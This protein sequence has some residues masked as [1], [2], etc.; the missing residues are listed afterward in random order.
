[1]EKYLYWILPPLVG[2]VIGYVTNAL[3]I[4]MLFRPLTEKR[5]FGLRVPFTP[6]ILPRER[7]TLALSLGDVVAND[8]L[9]TEVLRARFESE[10]LRE[11]VV[12]ALRSVLDRILDVS[13]SGA[14]HAAA[15]AQPVF[16][17]AVGNAYK[18]VSASDAFRDAL[19][20]AVRSAL[21]AVETLQITDILAPGGK[22]ILT[23]W[24]QRPGQPERFSEKVRDVVAR[25]LEQVAREGR[26]LGDIL[27]LDNLSRAAGAAFDAAYPG[28]VSAV[29]GFL[30]REDVR[31]ELERYGGRLIRRAVG[32]LSPLQRFFVSAAQYEKAI[33]ESMPE[34]VLDL[35]D[36]VVAF[37]AADKMRERLRSILLDK[38]RE[39]I[40]DPLE[41]RPPEHPLSPAGLAELARRSALALGERKASSAEGKGFLDGATLG[42]L[43]DSL[44]PEAR[45]DVF[46]AIGSWLSGLLSPGSGG[47]VFGIFASTFYGRLLDGLEG[48]PLGA[49]LGWDEGFRDRLSR[50]LA[51]KGMR[52]AAEESERILRG[53]DLR[54]VVTEK[55]DALDMLAIEGILLRVMSREFQGITVLGGVLGALIGTLQ[56]LI[57][58]LRP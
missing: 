33:L 36:S 18:A 35:A 14:R 23:E 7:H 26:S 20:L 19:A 32:R 57:G 30:A 40:S 4:K 12:N 31:R 53:I 9:T 28:L 58:Q 1:M 34:T 56:P 47:P 54:R 42:E 39:A 52:I 16:A 55:V 27:P 51:E 8:L 50:F 29:K 24:F 44:G 5:I 25:R 46:A 2:A 48:R 41:G 6:G 10:D 11:G 43:L 45:E 17:E 49:A 37:L 21:Q 3:A 13:V 15:S 22:S 38:I